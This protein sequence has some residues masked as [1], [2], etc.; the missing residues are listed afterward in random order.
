MLPGRYGSGRLVLPCSSIAAH[1][2]RYTTLSHQHS[3]ISLRA[4]SPLLSRM[5]LSVSL[6]RCKAAAVFPFMQAL[7]LCNSI[8]T[9]Y[10]VY[11]L[12]VTSS[13]TGDPGRSISLKPKSFMITDV[14][15]TYPEC[16]T[17]RVS[18]S[19]EST[20]W[21]SLGDPFRFMAHLLSE[22]RATPP[23][24]AQAMAIRMVRS[25]RSNRHVLTHS[26]RLLVVHSRR[27]SLVKRKHT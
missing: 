2:H 20:R 8:G 14:N 19:N 5:E 23:P 3:L 11:G 16:V 12:C 27:T 10:E 13:L 1:L 26:T 9:F 15:A 21:C 18:S 4:V 17:S 25:V 6:R 24:S 22:Q 7:A